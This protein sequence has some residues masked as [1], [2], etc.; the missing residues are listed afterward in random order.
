MN[1]NLLNLINNLQ[2]S[3]IATKHSETLLFILFKPRFWLLGLV[4]DVLGNFL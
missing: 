3:L 4:D 1:L 2:I